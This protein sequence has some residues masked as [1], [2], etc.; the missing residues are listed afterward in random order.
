ML[1]VSSEREHLYMPLADL[2]M[3]AVPCNGAFD[4]LTVNARVFTEL[5]AI[6]PLLKIEEVA[7]ELEGFGLTQQLESERTSEVSFQQCRCLLKVRQHTRGIDAFSCGLRS[8]A[9]AFDGSSVR[10]QWRSMRRK[11]AVLS[12]WV[13]RSLANVSVTSF[14]YCFS[15]GRS[16]PDMT[17]VY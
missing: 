14:A 12:R 10:H 6:R 9:L 11:A 15:R 8:K 7:E 5:V 2:N 1:P 3:V 13:R 4:D 17:R 16:K